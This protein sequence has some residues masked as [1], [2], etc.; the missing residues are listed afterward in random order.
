MVRVFPVPAIFQELHLAFYRLAGRVSPASLA[1]YW[2]ALT[3]VYVLNVFSD[4]YYWPICKRGLATT[5]LP[6]LFAYFIPFL[7]A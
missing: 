1:S 4:K 2:I 5:N 7:L 6:G 3:Y